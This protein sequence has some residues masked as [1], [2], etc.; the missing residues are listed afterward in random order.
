MFRAECGSR[1]CCRRPHLF[2]LYSLI[3]HSSMNLFSQHFR[4]FITS[5]SKVSLWGMRNYFFH[6]FN[7]AKPA[8]LSGK[9]TPVNFWG[10]PPLKEHLWRVWFGSSSYSQYWG[11]WT[12]YTFSRSICKA[13][14]IT[15]MVFSQT[16]PLTHQWTRELFVRK[17]ILK[18]V[19][20]SREI[21]VDW[22]HFGSQSLLSHLFA[23]VYSGIFL[24]PRIL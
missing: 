24:H 1:L 22:F 16:C 17:Y 23:I 4:Q 21:I 13:L 11:F 14:A 6:S 10:D 8:K 5:F 2:L 3:I 20:Q 15:S 9:Q 19:N 12:N 18:V 7:M